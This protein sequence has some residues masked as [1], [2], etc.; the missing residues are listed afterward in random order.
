MP[1]CRNG[2]RYVWDPRP[3][4]YYLD[5]WEGRRRKQ[6]ELAVALLLQ[7][8]FERHVGHKRFVEAITRADID[9]YKIQRCQEQSQRHNR[10][11]TARTVNLSAASLGCPRFLKKP[12]TDPHAIY[13]EIVAL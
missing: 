5:W 11:I 1:L 9:E 10:L 2:T 12:A 7:E 6:H 8:H 13:V 3:G 4:G